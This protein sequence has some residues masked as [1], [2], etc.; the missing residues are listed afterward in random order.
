MME[1]L[2]SF[3]QSWFTELTGLV[4]QGNKRVFV[5]YLMSAAMIAVVWLM[6]QRRLKFMSAVGWFFQRNLWWSSSSRSDYKLM[7]LNQAVMLLLSPLLLSK[8][9]LATALFY[10]LNDWITRPLWSLELSVFWASVI[11]TSC[12]FVV[13]DASR[14]YLHR[15][16]HRWPALWAFHRVH[17]TAQSLTPFTVL[18]THPM[19]G[20]LFGLRSTMVQGLMIGLFVF[21]LGDRVT[22]FS[23]LGANVFTA[24]FN[25]LGANLRH[26]PVPISYGKALER[27][28]IS[29]A[30]HQIHH[31]QASKH[32]NRNFGVVL[33]VWDRLGNTLEYGS[34]KQQLTY[35]LP[36]QKPNEQQLV[37]LYWQPFKSCWR[38]FKRNKPN[39][40]SQ[41]LQVRHDK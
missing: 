28:F 9:A 12:L 34:N 39:T 17:H 41:A 31:S 7:V 18:R 3:I 16:M 13:D 19:E 2:L 25:L 4:S 14:Y 6:W 27:W 33:A 32:W 21:L 24:V 23:L 29:P 15:L 35:G 26:S 5:G 36:D 10:G 22:L 1:W 40:I 37:T 38:C 11:F 8:L 20:V 30:Q